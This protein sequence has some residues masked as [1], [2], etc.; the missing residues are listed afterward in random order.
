MIIWEYKTVDHPAFE[1][2][3]REWDKY[4][5]IQGGLGW[6]LVQVISEKM[7]DDPHIYAIHRFVFKRRLED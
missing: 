4:L 6:E 7:K 2:P 1:M 3:M 5:N